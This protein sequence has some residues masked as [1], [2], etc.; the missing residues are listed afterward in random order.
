MSFLKVARFRKPE[1]K[2]QPNQSSWA[3]GMW[4]VG[5][6]AVYSAKIWTWTLCPVNHC[7]PRQNELVRQTCKEVEDPKGPRTPACS[8][9]FV[10]EPLLQGC[11]AV[12]PV[13]GDRVWPGWR[14]ESE[15]LPE[16]H[17]PTPCLSV[18]VGALGD[19]I[20]GWHSWPF[21]KLSVLF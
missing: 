5:L 9:F 2:K 14:L 3:W 4:I 18:C 10:S 13:C 15:D 11:R 20:P 16:S 19:Q 21:L 17:P 8:S 7:F 1:R 6:G 12:L